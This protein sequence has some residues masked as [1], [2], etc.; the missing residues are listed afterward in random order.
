MYSDNQALHAIMFANDLDTL[1]Y[2]Y[3]FITIQ[4]NVTFTCDD[5]LRS[6][7]AYCKGVKPP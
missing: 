5:V 7:Y 6:R 4:I 2:M 1:L 3:A